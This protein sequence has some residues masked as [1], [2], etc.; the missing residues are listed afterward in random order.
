MN[1]NYIVRGDRMCAV[2]EI[3]RRHS[4][5]ERSGRV[6]IRDVRRKQD[7]TVRGKKPKVG[8]SARDERVA[9]TISRLEST[10]GG[11][12]LFDNAN[13]FETID[14]WP[15]RHGQVAAPIVDV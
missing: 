12:N 1:H 2:Q 8:V 9:N 11:A 6:N 5:Q 10:Y 4:L 14:E 13:P 7:R 3:F 15:S